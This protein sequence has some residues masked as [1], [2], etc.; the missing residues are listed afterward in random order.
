MN[1][2]CYLI[3]RSESYN[4][5]S[6]RRKAPS[7]AAAKKAAETGIRVSRA[8]YANIRLSRLTGRWPGAEAVTGPTTATSTGSGSASGDGLLATL[9]WSYESEL[10]GK[11]GGAV[12]YGLDSSGGGE[13][14][15]PRVL[16]R[17]PRPGK[18]ATGPTR[19]GILTKPRSDRPFQHG[20]VECLPFCR[21]ATKNFSLTTENSVSQT[22][23]EWPSCDTAFRA[24]MLV[25]GTRLGWRSKLLSR[26]GAPQTSNIWG[27]HDGHTFEL[28]SSIVV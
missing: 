5:Q 3:Y 26:F 21:P 12:L 24:L 1:I 13:A 7:S 18:S 25:M 28:A 20:R 17:R 4:T 27:G 14:V 16:R 8:F 19:F 10:C 22:A 15:T 11:V 2:F 6:F 23:E 9:C